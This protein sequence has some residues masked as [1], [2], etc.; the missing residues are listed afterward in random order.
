MKTLFTAIYLSLILHSLAI[1]GS[2]E[3]EWK[4]CA[5][6]DSPTGQVHQIRI[7]EE[8]FYLRTGEHIPNGGSPTR[9]RILERIKVEWR[10]PTKSKYI[11][12][13]VLVIFDYETGRGIALTRR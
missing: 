12:R 13:S 3:D 2:E 5:S 9:F 1:G 4:Y 11:D 8:N 6:V 7:G 10:D